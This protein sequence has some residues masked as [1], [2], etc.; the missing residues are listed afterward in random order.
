MTSCYHNNAYT[1][2]GRQWTL[3]INL[4]PCLSRIH[5]PA[6]DSKQYNWMARRERH[7]GV[8]RLP[9]PTACHDIVNLKMYCKHKKWMTKYRIK[10][11]NKIFVHIRLLLRSRWAKYCD[12][13]VCMSLGLS[14]CP[15]AYL[16]TIRLL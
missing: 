15:L 13:R 14:L 1:T 12:Q 3:T 9:S 6:E 11:R 10:F 2:A 16:K 7:Y 4:S 8:R 5:S